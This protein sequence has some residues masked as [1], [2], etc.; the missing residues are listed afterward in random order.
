[1][2]KYNSLYTSNSDGNTSECQHVAYAKGTADRSLSES[3]LGTDVP[4]R[5]WTLQMPFKEKPGQQVAFVP[6]TT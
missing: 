6:L 2:I 5:K 4:A 3:P 1:M